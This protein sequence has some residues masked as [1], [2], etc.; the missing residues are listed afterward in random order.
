MSE[1]QG[2]PRVAIVTGAGRGIG[3]AI[4]KVLSVQNINIIIADNGGNIDGSEEDRTIAEE[5]IKDLPGPARAFTKNIASQEAAEELAAM[6]TSQFGAIDIVINC[7]AILKDGLVFKGKSEDWDEVIKNNLS[8]A[9]YL[10]K[11]TTPLLRQQFKDKR[12][13][14]DTYNW[15]RIINIGSTAGL[16]GNFGQA[17]YGSA[18]AGLFGLTRVT[19]LE[20]SRSNVTCNYVAPFAHS[21]VTELI[22]PAN[23][24][25]AEYK[26]RAL[27]VSPDHVANFISYLCSP[28]A[29]DVTG[30]LFGVRGKEI[31]LFNQPRPIETIVNKVNNWTIDEL[32]L[33]VDKNFKQKFTKLETDLE[34]F[35]TEPII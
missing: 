17:N 35:N 4:A 32:A 27:K 18:K 29:S 20:M 16:Y 24:E 23:E 21:R 3:K 12:G 6:A 14:N 1:N 26:E 10:I 28:L 31:F 7:A 2:E 8:S 9:F 11:A 5:A 13:S 25:Q 22:K 19:A 33:A 34:A 15:G 30:Q